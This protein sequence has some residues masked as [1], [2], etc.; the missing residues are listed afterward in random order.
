M[1]VQL[2]AP[3]L[4]IYVQGNGQCVTALHKHTFSIL[5]KYSGTI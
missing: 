3:Y 5:F 1:I 2:F 4:I